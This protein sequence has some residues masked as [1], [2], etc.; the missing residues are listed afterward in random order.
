MKSDSGADQLSS[1]DLGNGFHKSLASAIN[2]KSLE[3]SHSGVTGNGDDLSFLGFSHFGD[4][5]SHAVN[6]SL[7]IDI[8]RLVPLVQLDVLHHGKIHDAGAADHCI[9]GCDTVVLASS[10]NELLNSIFI[11]D[12]TR[13]GKDLSFRVGEL[14][15]ASLRNL[16]E[17]VQTTSADANTGS[18]AEEPFSDF[19]ADT[20]TGTDK[21]DDLV[22]EHVDWFY[23]A[24]CVLVWKVLFQSER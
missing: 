11:G 8:D 12:I 6:G 21:A 13:D 15:L 1:G 22:D 7:A 5:S 17:L 23:L 10:V 16:L 2:S 9:N 14:V 18:L 24:F 19:G 20:R 4:D 3:I